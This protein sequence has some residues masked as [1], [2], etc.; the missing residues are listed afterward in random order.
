[1]GRVA[2]AEKSK[3]FFTLK[4]FILSQ[5]KPGLGSRTGGCYDPGAGNRTTL[6]QSYFV[7][8]I[9]TSL[10]DPLTALRLSALAPVSYGKDLIKLFDQKL[11]DDLLSEELERCSV[12]SG[13][14]V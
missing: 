8:K 12:L 9:G 14:D 1:M 6:V 13:L 10:V 7:R 5:K 11:K 3:R 2:V 4:A